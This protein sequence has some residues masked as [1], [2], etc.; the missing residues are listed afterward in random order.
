[1]T[2]GLVYDIVYPYKSIIHPFV[3]NE[4]NS[5]FITFL[6]FQGQ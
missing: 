2:F 1:M 3:W 6:D 4:E 5:L